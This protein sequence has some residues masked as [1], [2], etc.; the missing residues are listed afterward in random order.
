MHEDYY[1]K[2]VIDHE[3]HLETLTS[4]VS[5]LTNIVGSTN[6]KLDDVIAVITQ[7]NVLVERMNNLDNNV[8]DAFKREGGRIDRLEQVSGD[9]GCSL[10]KKLCSSYEVLDEK[11]K[12]ANK[13]IDT[14]NVSVKT[15]DTKV[16]GTVSSN[17]VRWALSLLMVYSIGFGTYV[18]SSLHKFDNALVSHIA[19]DNAVKNTAT[20][21]ALLNSGHANED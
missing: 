14:T 8:A 19:S 18:V 9:S 15:V 16:E 3:K 20:R 21:Q 5:H 11:L 1:R 6:S 13:R 10:A 2:M 12:V 4:S 17:V 7:Q